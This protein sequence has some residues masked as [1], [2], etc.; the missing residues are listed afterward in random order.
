MEAAYGTLR[1][2]SDHEDR[3]RVPSEIVLSSAEHQI[4]RSNPSS[5]GAA[6]HTHINLQYISGVHCVIRRTAN[7]VELEDRSSN[8][9]F[10]NDEKVGKNLT[11]EL[12]TG[13]SVTLFKPQSEKNKRQLLC[14]IFTDCSAP[15]ASTGRGLTSRAAAA[16]WLRGGEQ[17][18]ARRGGATQQGRRLSRDIERLTDELG[19]RG[20]RPRRARRRTLAERAPRSRPPAAGGPACATASRRARP[21]RAARARARRAARRGARA[22]GGPGEHGRST[23]TG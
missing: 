14:Y 15:P 8:G 1:L 10:V 18:A 16:P 21:A 20:A 12:R 22:R 23:T 5:A 19:R 9:T 2:K 4:G 3:D 13:D 11:R 7:R 6:A 17:D